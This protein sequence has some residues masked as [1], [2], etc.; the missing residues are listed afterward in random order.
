MEFE[1]AGD[2]YATPIP[3]AHQAEQHRIRAR[4]PEHSSPSELSGYVIH[5]HED[6]P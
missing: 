6:L 5:A 1:P 4:S 2:G 3:P